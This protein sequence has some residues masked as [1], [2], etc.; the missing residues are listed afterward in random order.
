MGTLSQS[1]IYESGLLISVS[2]LFFLC[3]DRYFDAIYF[4]SIQ[5]RA[6]KWINGYQNRGFWGCWIDSQG[7]FCMYTKG[8]L[9]RATPI[10]TVFFLTSSIMV[11]ICIMGIDIAVFEDTRSIDGVYLVCKQK[12]FVI[13]PRPF[14]IHVNHFYFFKIGQYRHHGY[15]HRVFIEDA[16]SIPGVCCA[17]KQR[18]LMTITYP[19]WP[20]ETI[21]LHNCWLI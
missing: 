8:F 15:R 11:N 3:F 12:H 21:E 16:E 19:F 10:S 6:V 2:S 9:H 14:R 17:C 7:Q 4:G 18:H 5:K 20:W 13:G 1:F